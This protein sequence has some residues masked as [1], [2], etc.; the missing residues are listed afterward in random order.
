MSVAAAGLSRFVT[1]VVRGDTP[2]LVT[3]HRTLVRATSRNG[4]AN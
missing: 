3:G 1:G 4:L 2:D